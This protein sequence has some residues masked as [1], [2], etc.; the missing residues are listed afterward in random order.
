MFDPYKQSFLFFKYTWLTVVF[1]CAAVWLVYVFRDS[2]FINGVLYNPIVYLPN[3][4]IHE[5]SHRFAGPVMM[6]LGAQYG[7]AMNFQAVLVIIAGNAGETLVPVFLFFCA[8][9]LKGGRM[10]MPPLLYWISTTWYDVARYVSDARAMTFH[11]ASS[12][13]VSDSKPGTKGDWWYILDY[14]DALEYDILIGHVFYFI[15][16]FCLV[17]AI[18]SAWYIF[19]HLEEFALEGK[20]NIN[21]TPVKMQTYE[22]L[23]KDPFSNIVPPPS[24]TDNSMHVIKI[25]PKNED[26]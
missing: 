6:I 25:K 18:F 17:M 4:L 19:T 16:A 8:L 12:D 5:F 26:L 11:L 24:Q 22:E 1:I 23:T 9:R 20:K 2:G 3:F 14:F 7:D 21:K 15:A 13:M 10:L